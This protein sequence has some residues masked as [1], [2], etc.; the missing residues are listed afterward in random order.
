MRR[1]PVS[2]TE[3]PLLAWGD[4][5]RAAKRRRRRLRRRMAAVGCSLAL[6]LAPAI[7]PPTPRLVWNAS[8]SAP[9]G[10]YWIT[11]GAS[12][13]P[14]EMAVARPPQAFRRMAA[15]RHYLPMNVPLVKRAVATAGDEVCALGHQ[16]FLNGR[17]LTV[18]KSRDHAGRP[19]PMWLGCIR[20][21]GRQL[22]LLMDSPASFDG[23]YFG[24]TE[25]DDVIGGARLLW[26]R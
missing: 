26:A 11:P 9:M 1:R 4:A 21:R 12:I 25:G 22:F 19:M 6:L 2:L 8:T 24:V 13:E 7:V 15:E 20:L 17:W 18:R 3:T 10:L 16:I 14:G 5:L 23:R